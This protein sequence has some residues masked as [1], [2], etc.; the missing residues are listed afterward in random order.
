MLIITKYAKII[1][2]YEVKMKKINAWLKKFFRIGKGEDVRV[3]K[4]VDGEIKNWP[5]SYIAYGY[6][7]TVHQ[8]ALKDGASVIVNHNKKTITFEMI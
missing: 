8:S 5:G 1:L 4:V 3:F 2:I 7:S 6:N